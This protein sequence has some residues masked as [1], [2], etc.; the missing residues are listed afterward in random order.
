MDTDR[1]LLFG[2]LALQ[3]DVI[4]P[5]QFI[6]ACTLWSSRKDVPLAGLLAE[7]GWLTEED[8]SHVEYLLKRKLGK[9]AGDP[10]ASLAA[11]TPEFVKDVLAS[12][13]DPEIQHSLDGF[14]PAADGS[15]IH[16]TD[17]QPEGGGR[18]QL[19][20]LHAKGGVGRVWLARDQDLGRE[21]A[22]K[23]LLPE[24]AA[25]PA[26]LARFL[27]EAR[28][29][30][31][32]EHPGIVPVYEL[33]RH[34]ESRQPFYTM[35]F[36]RGR[37]LGAAIRD[38]HARRGSGQTGPLELRELLTS[39]VAVCNAVAYAHSRG[40]LHRDLK[41][42]N[43]ILGDFG[44]VMIL[45]WGLAKVRGL[46][47]E[48]SQLPVEVGDSERAETMQGQ[49]LGTPAYLPPEQAQGRLDR[50]NERSDVY[51]L[52]AILYEI[53]TGQAPFPGKDTQSVLARVIHEFPTPPCRLV[54]GTPRPLEAICL[55]AL[56][57]RSEERYPSAKALAQDLEH[58]LADEP[59]A[60]LPDP[61][62]VKAR[63][64]L[65]RHRTL[66]TG[67]AAT[68]LVA[69]LSLAAATVVLTA[70]KDR[71]RQ[72]RQR[73]EANM[74]LA[75]KA[76]D[77]YFTRVSENPELKGQALERLR[78][79]LLLEA[80]EFYEQFVQQEANELALQAERGEAYL[81][82]AHITEDL[83][84]R[85]EAIV[86]AR[87]AQEIFEGL[88]KE[89]ATGVVYED[90]LGRA[91]TTVGRNYR[92]LGEFKPAQET[93][94][95]AVELQR[96]LAA[97]NPGVPAFQYLLARTVN[98]LGLLYVR[99]L[100]KLPEGRAAFKE[101]ETLCEQLS[102]KFPEEP[103]YRSELARTFVNLMFEADFTRKQEQAVKEG[104]RA[105]S[106]L[107]K[108]AHDYPQVA[109]YQFRLAT[110]WSYIAMF[111]YNNRYLKQ[112]LTACAN[113]LSVAEQLARS[114][115]DVPA[116]KNRVSEIRMTRA[117]ILAFQGDH[118]QATTEVDA[119]ERD[120]VEG[121]V[122]YN[123][124]CAYCAS[125]TVARKD[126]NLSPIEREK[127]ANHYLDRAMVLL[128]KAKDKTPL[129]QSAQGVHVLKIDPELDPLRQRPD[130]KAFLAQVEEEA[131]K[132]K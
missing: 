112:G 132:R 28:V 8:K 116:Y 86:L 100:G 83:G 44:E 13:G 26:V 23:E 68:V 113:A 127:L 19:L 52:G 37:T 102:Q 105:V 34:A 128:Q 24:R 30:G 70:A 15:V 42:Q 122:I 131:L 85:S 62:L 121:N 36:L 31:Q 57:K 96:K 124:A 59:V 126:E 117:V 9:H 129:F 12:L 88:G 78:R 94:Q 108:L 38:Y 103:R 107:E 125:A 84:E 55:K 51:G 90:G 67:A 3:A 20:H 118:R 75:R 65:G 33:T 106:E 123:G 76:V 93:L 95:R 74:A 43:V 35:R 18:Y 61:W 72:A 63:R 40:V 81:R 2:V 69:A 114:H 79:S 89:Q 77:H 92:E 39:L 119:A 1:N 99:G 17:Y 97:S 115:P 87:Q 58:W 25:Q 45:D 49:V 111:H 56:A 32:L 6:E 82:L 73:A 48:S 14:R 27:E 29:T 5:A 98:E 71:E 50:I 7:R 41:P 21:V 60:A 11:A 22:L 54:A 16:T 53:L 64:W 47:D 101:A 109:D 46:A 130:F 104:E 80:K 91:L 10:R 110:A 4:T 66:A 120:A